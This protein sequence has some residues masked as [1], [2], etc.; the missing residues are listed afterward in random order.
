MDEYMVKMLA[1]DLQCNQ[2]LT[3]NV[4]ATLLYTLLALP[5]AEKRGIQDQINLVLEVFMP[6][7]K[8]QFLNAVFWRKNEGLKKE[9]QIDIQDFEKEINS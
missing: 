1:Q 9:L 4:T 5:F 2:V 7:L 6:I 3:R 8:L